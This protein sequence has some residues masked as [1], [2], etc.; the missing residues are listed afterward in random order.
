MMKDCQP[1]PPLCPIQPVAPFDIVTSHIVNISNVSKKMPYV[2][3]FQDYFRKYVEATLIPDTSAASIVD[4]FV[5]WF[6][7]LTNVYIYALFSVNSFDMQLR[8]GASRR[9]MRRKRSYIDPILPTHNRTMQ[10]NAIST[11]MIS[12]AS[13]SPDSC[14]STVI[15]RPLSI[16]W[17]QQCT[18][19]C[20]LT[21]VWSRKLLNIYESHNFAAL[22][23]FPSTPNKFPDINMRMLQKIV[24]DK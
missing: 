9:G 12:I 4:T 6:S 14:T 17:S 20:A 19:R 5:M 8:A 23:L 3:V 15:L 24:Y 21:T 13:K 18:I 1:P 11:I 10:T 2:I 22:K 7:S 16:V